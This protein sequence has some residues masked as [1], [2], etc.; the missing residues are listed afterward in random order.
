MRGRRILTVISRPPVAYAG[1]CCCLPFS[2]HIT[3]TN[4]PPQKLRKIAGRCRHAYMPTGSAPSSRKQRRN[5]PLFFRPLNRFLME[6]IR[7]LRMTISGPFSD[8]SSSG[9][10][11]FWR[12]PATLDSLFQFRIVA[13]AVRS[14][15]TRN[16]VFRSPDTR[17]RLFPL[18]L[19]IYVH[20]CFYRAPPI[21]LKQESSRFKSSDPAAALSVS[22]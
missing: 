1:R 9:E 3:S 19:H 10:F 13:V 22:R 14:S 11:V 5:L 12:Y 8:R 17:N 2:N 7:T 21:H 15:D 18:P 20:N 6:H 16:F 4:F